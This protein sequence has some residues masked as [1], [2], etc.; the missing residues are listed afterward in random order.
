MHRKSLVPNKRQHW[1]I[2]GQDLAGDAFHPLV[3]G[4]DFKTVHQMRGQA[5]ALHVGLDDDRELP[6]LATGFAG[7]AGDADGVPSRFA[8]RDE[9]H[10]PV[11]IDLC[12]ARGQFGGE[13]THRTEETIADVLGR[14]AGE[15]GHVGLGVLRPDRADG[16]VFGA[17][18]AV[19]DQV[20]GIGGDGQ[21]AEGFA[22]RAQADP[23]VGGDDAVGV[24]EQGRDLQGG[25]VGE[26][27]DQLADA[28][29]GF[30]DRGG[31]RGGAVP[32]RSAQG[33]ADRTAGDQA[34][35]QGQVQGW[36]VDRLVAGQHMRAARAEADH[37]AEG[38][39]DA[40]ADGEFAA[41]AG[42]ALDQQRAVLAAAARP[43][44]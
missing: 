36:Q 20:G 22:G 3:P 43:S 11:V 5:P 9:G 32:E 23:G 14:Q 28:D 29:Q 26:V 15:E 25:D 21:R 19:L 12:E 35:R 13:F 31:V 7:Q 37:G 33:R 44:G 42:M 10:F 39:V 34:S 24:R 1:V 8:H 18:R 16:E 30:G 17:D 27:D 6:A 2:V 40:H 4:P 41:P 38:G